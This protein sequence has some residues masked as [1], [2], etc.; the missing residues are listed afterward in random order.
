MDENRTQYIRKSLEELFYLNLDGMV[1]RKIESDAQ[2]ILPGH[3]FA[4]VSTE[5]FASYVQGNYYGTISLA[6]SLAEAIAKHIVEREKLQV[7]E[8]YDGNVRR[9]KSSK[10]ISE[11]IINL[12]EKIRGSNKDRNN[13]HHLNKEIEQDNKKLEEIAK[14]KITL[15]SNLE[16]KVFEFKT[17]DG[18][19]E[20]RYPQYWDI[21]ED[22]TTKSFLRFD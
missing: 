11:E 19:I 10:K 7:S 21:N 5:C 17:I 6:Q 22:F 13:Y 12:I 8:T 14:E 4:P 20:L 16:K 15:L 3:H 2:P 18:K 1:K 9:L